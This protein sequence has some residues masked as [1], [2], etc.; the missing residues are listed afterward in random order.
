MRFRCSGVVA[1]P[2]VATAYVNAGL[3][4][5]HRVHVAFDDQRAASG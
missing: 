5:A 3:M 4:Q 2:S 1:V